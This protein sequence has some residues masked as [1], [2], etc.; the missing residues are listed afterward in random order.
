MRILKA[1]GLE[2]NGIPVYA[3]AAEPLVCEPPPASSEPY[4]GADGLGDA[5][6]AS[7]CH[8]GH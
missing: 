8:G 6:E 7:C 3:G 4:Y 1:C 5:P 2:D